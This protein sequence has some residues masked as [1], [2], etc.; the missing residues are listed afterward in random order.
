M[1]RTVLYMFM[2][3]VLALLFSSCSSQRGGHSSYNKL[4]RSFYKRRYATNTISSDAQ[5][6]RLRKKKFRKKNRNVPVLASAK[7]SK[8][9]PMAEYDPS[10]TPASTPA[11]KPKPKPKPAPKPEPKPE[12]KAEPVAKNTSGRDIDNMND[13]EKHLVEDIVLLENDLPAPTSEEHEKVRKEVEKHL[14]NFD[15]EKPIKLEPLYFITG[16]DEFA[17]VDMEPFLV[18]VEYALQGKHILIEGHTDH[19]GDFEANVALSIKRV[20]KIRELMIQM[21]VH[22]DHI[23]VIGYGEEHSSEAKAADKKQEER[24]V[25]FTVF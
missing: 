8:S 11:P 19:V 17:F 15:K 22:D 14:K 1:K 16:Q 9:V 7:N 18:A 6:S 13:E 12:P 21:G 3:A 4:N 24:R 23:S 20:E 2:I 25:D 5:C 10:D